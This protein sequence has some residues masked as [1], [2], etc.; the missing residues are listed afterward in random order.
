[1]AALLSAFLISACAKIEMPA[2][3]KPLSRDAMMLLGAKKMASD[4]PIFIRIFKAESELEVWKQRLD[5][6]FY[7]FKTYPICTWSGGLG[8]KLKQGDKQAPEGFYRV[9]RHRMNPNSKF[10]LSFN[11]GYPNRFDKAHRRTGN[12]LMVHGDCSSAGCYAM[13]DT[14]MEEIYAL[15][16]EAF[17]GGQ[18]E[19]WVH[20]F[21]FRMTDEAMAR[22]A[23]SKHIA[24][25]NTLK[26]AY[27][28][29]ERNRIPPPIAVC[30]RRYVV[31]A[32][33][34]KSRKLK[35]HGRCP[36][37]T[38]PDVTPFDTASEDP[39]SRVVVPG[40]KKRLAML[41]YSGSTMMGLT[42]TQPRRFSPRPSWWSGAAAP[43]TPFDATQYF[44]GQQR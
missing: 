23:D 18:S 9:N 13:T 1:M 35:P 26:P 31:N 6:R 36:R 3:L 10:H 34:P 5:G 17:I 16:R 27:D 2:H 12:F 21:P 14:L 8:P 37:F 43:R 20:A 38:T 32:I 28:L 4:T 24:F 7:H 15:A 29:F 42:K 33:A 19:F 41:Q 40:V 25:W 44:A 30:E 39:A 22:H 11:L